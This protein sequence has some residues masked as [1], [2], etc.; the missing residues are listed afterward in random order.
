LFNDLYAD[1]N[2][3]NAENEQDL[4]SML[5]T[6]NKW[7]TKWRLSVNV[8][9]SK[10]MHF[11]KTCKTRSVY[12]FHIGSTVLEYVHEY[13]YLGLVIN[14]HLNYVTTSDVL[15]KAAGRALGACISKFK[16]LKNMEYKTY[17]TIYETCINPVMNYGSEI[18][19][20]KDYTKCNTVQLRAMKFFLGVHKYT[21]NVG[22]RGE[23]GWLKPK[24]ERWK[25]IC[26]YW[27]RLMNMDQSRML[28]QIFIFDYHICKNNWSSEVKAIFNE[29]GIGKTFESLESCV[30]DDVDLKLKEN[31]KMCWEREV[32]QYSKLRTYVTFKTQCKQEKYLAMGLTRR[33]RSLYAQFR[34]GVLP[35]RLETG[36]FRGEKEEDRICTLCNSGDVENEMHFLLKCLLYENERCVL[37]TKAEEK[38]TGFNE[39]NDSDKLITLNTLLV[40]QTSIFICAA[41]NKRRNTLYK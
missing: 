41:Y 32:M 10:I 12:E 16:S 24:L 23:F 30:L 36:R 5:D 17:T 31:N 29:I 22:V 6:A 33:Q 15:V 25:N 40:C 26:R 18:W 37:F 13:K 28:Y 8:E 7:C 20:Y 21:P 1:D 3:L 11:R 4:Q 9:K 2:V 35:I 19:G 14:E 27:N 38:C 34:L 39:L